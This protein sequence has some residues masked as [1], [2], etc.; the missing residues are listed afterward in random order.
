MITN[1]GELQAAVANWP[2]RSDIASGG[3]NAGRVAEFIFLAEKRINRSLARIGAGEVQ[4]STLQTTTGVETTD[5]PTD[6][7]GARALA[8][9]D[10]SYWQ[11]E[12]VTPEQLDQLWPSTSQ[13]RPRWF[14]I[15]GKDGLTDQSQ[16]HWRPLPD[17]TYTVKLTYYRLV[18]TITTGVSGA[19]NWLLAAYPDAYLYASLIEMAVWLQ[20]DGLTAKYLQAYQAAFDDIKQMDQRR[21][22]AGGSLKVRPSVR[23]VKGM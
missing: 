19:S 13:Q 12:F 1:Y 9:V 20:D 23:H 3:G 15:I 17:A 11:L 14:A 10:S 2:A 7:N 18:P 22:Y 6:F 21:R 8:I 4:T 16:L 5:L